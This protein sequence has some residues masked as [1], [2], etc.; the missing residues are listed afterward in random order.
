MELYVFT[1]GSVSKIGIA[2]YG[3]ILTELND[4]DFKIIKTKSGRCRNVL[5]LSSFEAESEG[6]LHGLKLLETCLYLNK[7]KVK[8]VTLIV[9]NEQ[10]KLALEGNLS[11]IKREMIPLWRKIAKLRFGIISTVPIAC[12]NIKS[13]YLEWEKIKDAKERTQRRKEIASLTKKERRI[14]KMNARADKLCLSAQS[15]L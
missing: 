14:Y 2:S 6:L 12:K 15:I 9:D 3:A 7:G 10:I 4:D 11:A 8:S 5:T 1:D 13:H